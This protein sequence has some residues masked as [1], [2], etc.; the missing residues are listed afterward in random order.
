MEIDH[1]VDVV[2]HMQFYQ[3]AIA[4]R[5]KRTFWT[6]NKMMSSLQSRCV[7]VEVSQNK[8]VVSVNDTS[9]RYKRVASSSHLVMYGRS[10]AKS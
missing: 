9:A 3:Q 8:S 5:W 1:T 4:Q 6:G 2:M 7:R 10:L